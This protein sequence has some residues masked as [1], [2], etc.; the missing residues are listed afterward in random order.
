MV[1]ANELNDDALTRRARRPDTP[2]VILA[3][4]LTLIG[5][6][7]VVANVLDMF[8]VHA[9]SSTI[10][11]YTGVAL[12]LLGIGAW[13]FAAAAARGNARAFSH[14]A[15]VLLC[16]SG[17]F[18]ACELVAVLAGRPSSHMIWLA[19]WTI[20]LA[21][22]LRRR[23]RVMLEFKRRGLWDAMYGAAPPST[24][25]CVSATLLWSLGFLLPVSRTLAALF[26]SMS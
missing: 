9:R 1:A 11:M 5:V 7:A 26:Q 17:A 10:G 12:A 8:D 19:L 13:L 24:R 25:L 4:I 2:F 14:A 23:G 21:V 16:A 18:S 15:L 6:T 22:G 20:V 3:C